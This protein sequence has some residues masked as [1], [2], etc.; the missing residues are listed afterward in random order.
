[1][2][3]PDPVLAAAVPALP[4]CHQLPHDKLVQVPD[5]ALAAAAPAAKARRAANSDEP[6]VTHQ[7]TPIGI[8]QVRQGAGEMS[9]MNTMVVIALEHGSMKTGLCQRTLIGSW[10]VFLL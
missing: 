6:A 7:D 9:A 8:L 10:G 1:M 2:Q 3:V 4:V 5:P